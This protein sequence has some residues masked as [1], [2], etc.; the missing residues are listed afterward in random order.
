MAS[1]WE[2]PLSHDELAFAVSGLGALSADREGSEA[3]SF[4]RCSCTPCRSQ[5]EPG[6]ASRR[7]KH[8]A[9]SIRSWTDEGAGERRVRST[10]DAERGRFRGVLRG[11]ARAAASGAV[12]RD[13]QRRGGGRADAGRVRRGVGTMGL[14]GRHARSDRL[15]LPDRHEPVPE[16]AEIGESG[17]RS[18]CGAPRIRP[19]DACS[20]VDESLQAKWEVLASPVQ[21]R[22]CSS[23]T[24]VVTQGA[25]R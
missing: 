4:R 13:R 18:S 21:P 20:R 14:G 17:R 12:R 2:K 5:L 15:P 25:N 9:S 6:P 23:Y 24:A 7:P 3:W 22:G 11:R 16:P 1:T 19:S 10:G 8:K